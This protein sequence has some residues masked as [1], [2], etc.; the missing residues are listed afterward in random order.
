MVKLIFGYLFLQYIS[1]VWDYSKANSEKINKVI[2]DF[3]W[4]KAFEN[5][6]VDEKVELFNETLLN[7]YRN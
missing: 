1:E 5:L 3:N 2:S 7:I 4:T 6:S